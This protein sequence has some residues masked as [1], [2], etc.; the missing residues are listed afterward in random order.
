M[1]THWYGFY[2]AQVSPTCASVNQSITV[3]G[4]FPKPFSRNSYPVVLSRHWCEVESN[5]D[6]IVHRLRLSNHGQSALLA[7]VTVDPLE[8]GGIA[9]HLVQRWLCSV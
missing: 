2:A 7:I 5:E 6:E 9:V 3:Q 1:R 8:T 4:L